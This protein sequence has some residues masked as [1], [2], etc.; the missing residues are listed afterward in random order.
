[1]GSFHVKPQQTYQ[2]LVNT[3][4]SSQR[5][6]GLRQ[7]RGR[8][9][10]LLE[11]PLAGSSLSGIEPSGDTTIDTANKLDTFLRMGGGVL[12]S[13]FANKKLQVLPSNEL[14][15]KRNSDATSRYR[16]WTSSMSS[17]TA[18]RIVQTSQGPNNIKIVRPWGIVK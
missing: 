15:R 17:F 11:Y 16:I 5:T 7:S 1:M 2:L 18:F 8:Q 10:W 12:R 4:Y 3:Y 6:N 9:N 13:Y 14:G